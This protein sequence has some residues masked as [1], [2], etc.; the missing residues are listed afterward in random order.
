MLLTFGT[1]RY[2]LQVETCDLTEAIRGYSN[3]KNTCTQLVK[4]QEAGVRSQA[5]LV[6]KKPMQPSVPRIYKP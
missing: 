3:R 1:M 6:Y 2:G 5:S 4:H